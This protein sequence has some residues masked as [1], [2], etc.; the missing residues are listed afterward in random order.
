MK[1]LQVIPTVD[2]SV[3][4]VAPAM[5][6]LSRGLLRRGHQIEV[7]TVDP[8][9][10]PWL[11]QSD[12]PIHGVGSGLTTYAYSPELDRWLAAQKHN[13][14]RV[15]VNGMWQYPG[16]AVWRQFA[17]ATPYYVFPHGMLDPWFKRTYPLKH[18]KKW[19]YW[20]WA[21]YRI[22]RDATAV[23][24]T[25]EQERIEA[26]Q[27]FWLYRANERVSPLGV[28]PP[29][30]LCG[31]SKTFLFEE[32]PQLRNTRPLVFLGRIHP[33]KG[34]DIAIQAF[35]AAAG[36]RSGLSLVF[37]GPD[38]IGWQKQLES[39]TKRLGVADRVVFVGML[40]GEMKQSALLDADAFILPSHQEN[41]G[42][43]VVEALALG[44]PVLISN[45]I[46]I[47]GEIE[48]DGAG[49]VAGDDLAGTTSL[50]RRWLDT[51][52]TAREVMRRKAK[53]CYARRYSIE[54]AADS[55][56]KILCEIPTPA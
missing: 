8:P 28:E 6:A 49:Y 4:G 42:M 17:G 27:S 10:A 11:H 25:S 53:E 16:L 48:A 47:A 51:P 18:V 3:G 52:E 12:V 1:I 20:P 56:F 7:V 37:A 44:V 2:P 50:I 46:N 34:C 15:I 35:A 29:A 9:S 36:S 14:D 39:L 31:S 22:L 21:E 19:L 13:Y 43:A 30:E 5:L 45:R 41:F 33:K 40:Q 54:R 38:Q 23:I 32:F 55:L 24:Y 26:R